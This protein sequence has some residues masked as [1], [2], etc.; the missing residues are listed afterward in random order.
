MLLEAVLPRVAG[1]APL[2]PVQR[3][4]LELGEGEGP[5][6]AVETLEQFQHILARREIPWQGFT[7]AAPQS[8]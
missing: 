2:A 1:T 5:R 4:I 3:E 8:W 6:H 7:L